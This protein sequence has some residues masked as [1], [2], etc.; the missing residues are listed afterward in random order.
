M[1]ADS[2][3]KEENLVS[4]WDAETTTEKP[5]KDLIETAEALLDE[6]VPNDN[7]AKS[8]SCQPEVSS[9]V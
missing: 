4:K 9:V 2:A 5:P 8:F 3:Q 1:P 7:N 6:S